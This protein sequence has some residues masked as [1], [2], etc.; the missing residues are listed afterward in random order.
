MS[1][2]SITVG[3][4]AVEPGQQ[5]V[6]EIP[7]ASLFTGTPVSLTVVVLH[8]R[9]PGPTVW[10]D[11]AI[12]GDELNGL[13]IIRE[14]L[15][16]I[17]VDRLHGTLLAVP[18][19]NVLGHIQRSRYLPDRRDLNRCFPGSAR[20][21]L[22]SRLA[23]LFLEQ[24]VSHCDLGIDLHTAAA[25]RTNLPHV[26]TDLTDAESRRLAEIFG[27]PLAYHAPEIK[28]SLRQV[29]KKRGV[30]LLVYEAGE[31]L[32]FDDR[33]VEIGVDGVLRVLRHVGLWAPTTDAVSPPSPIYG[34]KGRWV[35]ASRS[36]LFVP[37]VELG[38]RV[39]KGQAL[40]TLSDIVPSRD[41]VM[42]APFDGMVM[43]HVVDPLVHQGDALLHIARVSSEPPTLDG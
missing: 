28:G 27:A 31:P 17:D 40:G 32:R 9:Q 2:Q 37:E 24:V 42:K 14:V 13:Q 18:V 30:A 34:R 3:K 5:A 41:R 12:H 10:L 38:D 33:A 7:M 36:G 20:G 39:E 21:S 11:A 4:T 16:Q 29:A 25:G 6:V 15:Q 8:G 19:V 23:H 22:A 35:R 43:G 26:R 1:R